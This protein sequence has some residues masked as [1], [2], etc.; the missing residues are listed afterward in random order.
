MFKNRWVKPFFRW[1]HFLG[2]R[3]LL[4][5]PHTFWKNL[6]HPWP[7]FPNRRVLERSFSEAETEIGFVL[8]SFMRNLAW[9]FYDVERSLQGLNRMFLNGLILWVLLCNGAV[10][11]FY[12]QVL[13][14]PECEVEFGVV[15][16]LCCSMYNMAPF[17]FWIDISIQGYVIEIWFDDSVETR[18]RKFG[19]KYKLLKNC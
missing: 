14:I 4:F 12:H 19:L 5:S 18:Q 17:F 10:K 8:G 16:V 11:T 3:Y 2:D 7:R 13:T 1:N 9:G 15:Y 6:L